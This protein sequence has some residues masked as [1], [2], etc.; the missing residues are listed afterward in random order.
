MKMKDFQPTED[1]Q[2]QQLPTC[3][4]Q[5]PP[6]LQKPCFSVRRDGTLGPEIP[7]SLLSFLNQEGY[8]DGF[9]SLYDP[10]LS[11]L[12]MSIHGDATEEELLDFLARARAVARQADLPWATTRLCYLLGRMSLRK[13]KLSQAR[14]YFEEALATLRGDFRD[15]YLVA[16]LYTHLTGIYLKQKNVKKS[17]PFL[18]KAA[19]L[20]MGLASDTDGAEMALEILKYAL[21]RAVLSQSR[22]A[23]A[24]ACFLLAKHCLSFKQGQEPGPFLERLQQ[25]LNEGQ[26]L[27]SDSGSVDCYLKLGQLYS[28]KCLPCLA[29]S[30]AKV[31]SSRSSCSL[32]EHFRTIDLVLRNASKVHSPTPGGQRHPSLVAFYLR[33]LLHALEGTEGS[34]KLRSVIYY[35]LS[36]LHSRYKQYEEAIGYMEEVLELNTSA[37]VVEDT[38][39][40]FIFLSWLY[41][42]QQQTDTAL[43]ILNAVAESPWSTRQQLGVI[44]NM[45]AI[46]LRQRNQP[47]RAV[48]SYFKALSISRETGSVANEAVAL[49]NLGIL[50]LHSSAQSL[51]EHFLIKAIELFSELSS[52]ECGGNFVAILLRLGHHYT[53]GAQKEKARNCYEWAFLVAMEREDVEGKFISQVHN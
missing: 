7:D 30:C 5:E 45:A 14:V 51:G 33:E 53:R 1:K 3:H 8:E 49:A 47:R 12:K 19:S 6:L 31:V 41:I 23:E 4:R 32:L 15:L 22:N 26:G 44:H 38:I 48:E 25:L 10:P 24:R 39:S 9:G 42:L 18:D 2:Q 50:C 27:P 36:Q 29:L 52:G 28:Q 21:K 17:A 43:C 35:E 37:R 13:F 34:Q 16:S 40:H 46:S 20:L 11:F